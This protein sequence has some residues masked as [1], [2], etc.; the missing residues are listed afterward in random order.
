[1]FTHLIVFI[2]SLKE[3]SGLFLCHDDVKV[4]GSFAEVIKKIKNRIM[5]VKKLSEEWYMKL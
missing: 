3:A 5:M 1:M 4:A 2:C